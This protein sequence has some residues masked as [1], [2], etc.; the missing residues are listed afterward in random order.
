MDMKDMKAVRLILKNIFNAFSVEEPTL[1]NTVC[2][3]AARITH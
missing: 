1:R 2:T 3:T